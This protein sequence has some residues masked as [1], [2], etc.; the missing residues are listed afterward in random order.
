MEDRY[1]YTGSFLNWLVSELKSAGWQSSWTT[2][3]I[4]YFDK[5]SAEG[6][7]IRF[8]VYGTYS[9]K[10]EIVKNGMFFSRDYSLSLLMREAHSFEALFDLMVYSLFSQFSKDLVGEITGKR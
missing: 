2:D 10:I 8:R 4:G 7:S 3:G 9:I 5:Q 1:K 6:L